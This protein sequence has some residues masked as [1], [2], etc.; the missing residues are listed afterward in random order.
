MTYPEAIDFLYTE[1]KSFEETGGD[2]YKP[3]LERVEA[4]LALFGNP[5]Q[6]LRTIHVA[7][8]NGK[9]SVSSLTA[10]VLQASGYKVGLFT[11]PHLVDFRERIRVGGEM[12]P[13]EEVTAFVERIAP[14]VRSREVEPSF[15]ELTTA[16]AFDYFK[17]AGT[18]YAVIE[19]GMGGRLDSTNVLTPLVS[20]ITNVSMDH[21]QYLGDTLEKIATEKAGI[22]K[23]SVP[24]VLGR[25][26]EPEVRSVVEETARRLSAPLVLADRKQEVMMY[27][28]T[29]DAYRL[30]T[31]HFGNLT[32][33][34]LGAYQIENAA[35]TLETLLL[36]RDLGLEIPEEAVREG[37]ARV[38]EQGLR[39]RLEVLREKAPRIIA[40]SGHNPGSW[41]Y[42]SSYLADLRK[43]RP[44]VCILGFSEDKDISKVLGLLPRDLPI[45]FTNAHTARAKNGG[46][47]RHLA[48]D[49]GFKKCTA[50]IDL[51]S[52]YLQ[53]LDMG[54]GMEDFT[55]FVGGSFYL[56][57]EF[58]RLIETK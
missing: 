1:T 3:G 35:T 24:V 36:L 41:V 44:V 6:A 38:R 48:E 47:L 4:L 23:P 46:K 29:D 53:A 37:F 39:A 50:A 52:A 27:F 17:K 9:G 12:I 32:L 28:R 11:S 42:L 7:G 56:V 20:V 54:K 57:G 55:I 51:S 8:T 31:T 19:T 18:D 34:L 43:D 2:A 21:T 49:L 33:P 22:I 10:S 14:A 26:K 5:H 13:E 40:D 45:I 16:M 30:S 58:L 25:S 15:F